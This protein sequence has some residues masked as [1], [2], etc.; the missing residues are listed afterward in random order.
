MGG[1]IVKDKIKLEVDPEVMLNLS[2][3]CRVVIKQYEADIEY[4]QLSK[5]QIEDER[6]VLLENITKE[7]NLLVETKNMIQKTYYDYLDQFSDD[8]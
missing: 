5:N 1:L 6:K 4:L 7:L 2:K 8:I 3:G